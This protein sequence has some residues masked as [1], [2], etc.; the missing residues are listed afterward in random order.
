MKEPRLLTRALAAALDAR[1]PYTAGHSE[2]VSTFAVAV[3][4]ELGLD[5]EARETLRLGATPRGRWSREVD[6]A[7]KAVE[8]LR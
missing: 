5:A 8:T 4:D 1:D 7:S 2:R 6:H 3:A